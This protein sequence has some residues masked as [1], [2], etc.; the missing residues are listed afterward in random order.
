MSLEINKSWFLSVLVFVASTLVMQGQSSMI[1]FDVGYAIPMPGTFADNSL[2]LDQNPVKVML[3]P[4]DDFDFAFN[5]YNERPGGYGGGMKFS[6][7]YQHFLND[8]VYVKGGLNLLYN[9]NNTPTSYY[10]G[11][12]YDR[13]EANRLDAAQHPPLSVDMTESYTYSILFANVGIGLG[14]RMWLDR[15]RQY[16]MQFSTN[17]LLGMGRLDREVYTWVED[18][19]NPNEAMLSLE[20]TEFPQERSFSSIR[21]GFKGDAEIGRKITRNSNLSMGI[22][23]L[24]QEFNTKRTVFSNN[25]ESFENNYSRIEGVFGLPPVDRPLNSLSLYLKYS[26]EL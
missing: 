22:E 25:Q 5:S 24:I 26:Y 8:H 14:A 17:V 20:A 23:L 11:Y 21:L 15:P 19:Q 10:I 9:E 7:G 4:P 18:P 1:S 12:Y 3:P 2:V 6:L 13:K 16:F